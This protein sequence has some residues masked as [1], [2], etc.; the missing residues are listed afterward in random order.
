M[1]KFNT[2]LTARAWLISEQKGQI[3]CYKM[4]AYMP[5]DEQA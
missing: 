5:A 3:V 4:R 1:D 2:E